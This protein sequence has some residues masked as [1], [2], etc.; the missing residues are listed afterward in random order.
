MNIPDFLLHKPIKIKGSVL[1]YSSEDFYWELKLPRST[2][3]KFNRTIDSGVAFSDAIQRFSIDPAYTTS[4]H[5]ADFIFTIPYVEPTS[6]PLRIL[7]LGSG[8]GNITMQ[9]SR[10]FPDAEI[11]AADASIDILEFLANR[12]QSEGVQNVTCVHI[13]PLETLTFPFKNETFDL[14][15]MNGVLE[16]V[17]AG[18]AIGNPKNYQIALLK[19][20]RTLLADNGTL[21]IGIE[22]RYFIGYFLNVKDPHSGLRYTSVMPRFIANLISKIFSKKPYRTY[23]YSHKGFYRLFSKAGF[24][25]EAVKSSFVWASYKDPYTI[26]PIQLRNN[27][28]KALAKFGAKIFPTNRIR[29]AF[30]VFQFLGLE[31]FFAPSFLFYLV[32]DSKA[33]RKT[34]AE[35][36]FETVTGNRAID[37]IKLPGS[38]RDDGSVYFLCTATNSAWNMKIP[39]SGTFVRL[40]AQILD[41]YTVA[42]YN[43]VSIIAYPYIEGRELSSYPDC[44]LDKKIFI[45]IGAFHST[46]PQ[47]HRHGD[48][49]TENIIV[50]QSGNLHCIDFDDYKEN[51]PKIYDLC[52]YFIHVCRVIRKYSPEYAAVF[53][54]SEKIILLIQQYDN[55]VTLEIWRA[56]LVN[57]LKRKKNIQTTRAEYRDY[58]SDL[59]LLLSCEA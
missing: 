2:I 30:K 45:F 34:L 33:E 43:N 23:L 47:L 28:H 4:I 8:F 46:L 55:S 18:V 21:Y 5:R 54:S 7:D 50:D 29:V 10:C 41:T 56:V 32:K 26:I 39:R 17:G 36:Y 16:W 40:P 3:Q 52:D 19:K 1:S 27:F 11:I 57:Y 31:I 37:S 44:I 24:R 6:R 51:E 38:T 48:L 9:L 13:P 59:L 53:L 35:R 14:I 20:L 22:N 49:T 25:N 42:E 58:I 15:I 12:L